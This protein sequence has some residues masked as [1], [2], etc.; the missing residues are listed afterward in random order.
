MPSILIHFLLPVAIALPLAAASQAEAKQSASEVTTPA[1]L[2]LDQA[3]RT[4]EQ[5]NEVPEIAEARIG[6]SRAA[7]RE[8]WALLLPTLQLNGTYVRRSHEVVREIGG[9]T[10]VIQA[11][12]GLSGSAVAELELLRLPAIPYIRSADREVEATRLRAD[13]LRRT[14]AFEVAEAFLTV[15]TADA[16]RGAAERR[17]GVAEA[18]VAETRQRLRAGLAGRNDLT[19]SELELATAAFQLTETS[20]FHVRARLILGYLMNADVPSQ[21]QEPSVEQIAA[22]EPQSLLDDAVEKRPDLAARTLDA[23]ALRIRSKA[24]WYDFFPRLRAVGTWRVTNEAGLSGRDSDWNVAGLLTWTLFDGGA[25]YAQAAGL[26]AAADEVELE[27]KALARQV[28]LQI[29]EAL[30][31]LETAQA[32]LAQASARAD[33][34]GQNEEEVRARF[35]V[36]L[37]TALEQADASAQRYEA[38]AEAARQ[39]FTLQQ[40]RL[41][42]LQALGRWPALAQADGA[43]PTPEGDS[44]Q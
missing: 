26:R 36:G 25:R 20:N 9:T 7:L 38:E 29:L 37:A 30:T 10:S 33:V 35:S 24:P 39:Q 4:A 23:Q 27:A 14:L 41:Q 5:N 43:V 12:D 2:T 19:R 21:L 22:E 11:R 31:N 42:L 8:A 16:M 32:A 1:V 6:Q 18:V 40:A 28:R 34:A 3:I 44:L 13:E 15:L 17:A